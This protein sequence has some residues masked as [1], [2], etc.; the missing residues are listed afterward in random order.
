[1]N[2]ASEEAGNSKRQNRML[3]I[4]LVSVNPA[5]EEAG[6]RLL[7]GDVVTDKASQ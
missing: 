6:N 3:R 2:P 5:S 1:V 4:K 7:F